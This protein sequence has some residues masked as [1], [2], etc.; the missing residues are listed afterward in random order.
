[1]VRAYVDAKALVERHPENALAHFALAYVLRY[2]GAMEES[3]HE[4]DTALSLD[5]GNYQFRSCAFTFDQL[6]KY[7]GQWIFSSSMPDR[8][9]QFRT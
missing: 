6:G 1:V 5:P 3:A 4:C 2:G 8:N 7:N 9:G